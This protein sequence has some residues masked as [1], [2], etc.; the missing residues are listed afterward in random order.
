MHGEQ[1]RMLTVKRIE[2]SESDIVESI[3]G[4]LAFT[5][6]KAQINVISPSGFLKNGKMRKHKSKFISKGVSDIQMMWNNVFHVFEVKRPSELK[7]VLKYLNKIRHGSYL[8]LNKKQL[9]LKDQMNYIDSIVTNGG[10]GGFVA[11]VEHV[12]EIIAQQ[13]KN[14]INDEPACPEYNR[15]KIKFKKK[16]KLTFLT[17]DYL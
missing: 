3:C 9:H 15:P 8:T 17:K 14:S 11:S 7:Y 2:P 13:D 6:P 10:I 1:T 16:I 4:Y 5:Y 12:E